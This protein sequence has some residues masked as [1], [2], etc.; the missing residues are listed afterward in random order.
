[1]AGQ[2]AEFLFKVT[3]SFLI[4]PVVSL[5]DV[6]SKKNN[7]SLVAGIWW[8]IGENKPSKITISGMSKT[9]GTRL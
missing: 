3:V 2:E 5:C 7:I 9:K 8:Q 4:K 1:M 6:L